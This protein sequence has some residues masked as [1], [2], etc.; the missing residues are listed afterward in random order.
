MFF[1]VSVRWKFA[2]EVA[3]AWFCYRDMEGRNNT[4]S[5]RL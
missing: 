4:G 3:V 1:I 2:S 5:V